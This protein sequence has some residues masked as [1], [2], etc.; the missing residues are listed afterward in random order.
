[1][2]VTTWEFKRPNGAN[3]AGYGLLELVI[4]YLNPQDGHLAQRVYPDGF[5]Y[6]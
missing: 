2:P 1:M 3:R 5:C 6:L 4:G